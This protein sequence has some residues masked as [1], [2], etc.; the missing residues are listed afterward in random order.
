M[1]VGGCGEWAPQ[2]QALPA[3]QEPLALSAGD[4][5]LGLG[6]REAEQS[7]WTSRQR[8][9]EDRGVG[10]QEGAVLGGS[11]AGQHGWVTSAVDE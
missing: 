5:S 8:A 4:R 2:A 7:R 1:C 11:G 3:L 6:H 9:R 10:R